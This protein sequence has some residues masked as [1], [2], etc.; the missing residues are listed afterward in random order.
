VISYSDILFVIIGKNWIKLCKNEVK[1][2]SFF[3]LQHDLSKMDTGKS[4]NT[5]LIRITKF[6]M[7]DPIAVT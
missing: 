6:K 3:S 1:D 2:R 4:L 7:V 5:N